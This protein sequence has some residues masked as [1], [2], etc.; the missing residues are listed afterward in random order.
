MT[1]K[2]LIQAFRV[3]GRGCEHSSRGGI[4]D[5]AKVSC[6]LGQEILQKREKAKAEH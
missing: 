5:V 1:F 3:G 6:S 2:A 4:S